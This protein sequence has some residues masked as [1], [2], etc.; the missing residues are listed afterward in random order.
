M[1]DARTRW[2]ATRRAAVPVLTALLASACG[3]TPAASS[4]SDPPPTKAVRLETLTP[5]EVTPS[6]MAPGVVE[7]AARIALAFRV[8]GFIARFHVDEGD[9]VEAGDLLA[10]L[11]RQEL[12]HA[13]R[14]ARAALAR[15]QARLADA[16][17][18][19]ERRTELLARNAT[20]V[21]HFEEARSAA[22]VARAERDEARVAVAEARDRLGWAALR[23][24]VDGV[25]AERRAEAHERATPEAP[26]LVLAQ[27]DPATVR[28]AVADT[29]AASLRVGAPARVRTSLASGEVLAGHIARIAVGADPAARTLPFEVEIPN[30]EGVLR[31]ELSVEV[32]VPTGAAEPVLLVPLAAVLRGADT[33]PFCFLAGGR[34]G[35]L[36][37]ERR[38][39]TLGDVH[40]ERVAIASGLAPGDRVVV[41]GQH[42]LQPG[43]RLRP[44]PEGDRDRDP[45]PASDPDPQEE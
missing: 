38:P 40:G 39:V 9:R 29:H 20:S 42:F 26:V 11:E 22:Q 23:A 3:E 21:R 37:A 2:A 12:Q 31:P 24:P 13:L 25:V 19:L 28:A 4:A 1:S 32:E 16:E 17:R 5:R 34:D 15:A 36:R 6:L 8:A 18:A 30:P 7:A 45:E 33:R 27:L 10:E 41:R 44:T 43:D 35:A 14:R